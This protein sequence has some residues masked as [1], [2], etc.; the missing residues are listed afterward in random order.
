MTVGE[1]NIYYR[2]N[3]INNTIQS[4]QE[5]GQF[6]LMKGRHKHQTREMFRYHL[7]K[8]KN[9]TWGLTMFIGAKPHTDVT[10][11]EIYAESPS[12]KQGKFTYDSAYFKSDF[13]HSLQ[14]VKHILFRQ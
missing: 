4:L 2:P 5:L 10:W 1:G 12:F 6:K 8:V 11:C 7:V 14:I 13:L 3:N 9:P